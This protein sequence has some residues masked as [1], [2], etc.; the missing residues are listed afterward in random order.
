[1]NQ[2][3]LR[4]EPRARATRIQSKRYEAF[5]ISEFGRTYPKP[6]DPA[7]TLQDALNAAVVTC[8]HKDNLV[9]KEIDDQRGEVKLHIYAVKRKSTP[10]YVYR[11]HE[12]HRE[13]RLYPELLCVVDG[14][15]IGIAA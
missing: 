9:I 5:Q 3:I 10:N 13:H 4:D 8:I 1:M 15:M 6:I 11:D 2:V 12:Y 14:N 7:E